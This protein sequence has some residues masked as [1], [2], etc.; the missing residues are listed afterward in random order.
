MEEKERI[1]ETELHALADAACTR[2]FTSRPMFKSLVEDI[3]PENITAYLD[4]SRLE[5]WPHGNFADI[6][7]ERGG[8]VVWRAGLKDGSWCYP[9]LVLELGSRP[10]HR[11]ALRM[12]AYAA[13]LLQSI[14]ER[15]GLDENGRLSWVLPIVLYSGA[16]DWKEPLELAEYF[17]DMPEDLARYIPH[18]SYILVDAGRV[19][20]DV[21][22]VA[23]DESS[24]L[25]AQFFR[26]EQVT[27]I[28]QFEKILGRL[29]ELTHVGDDHEDAAELKRFD[30][31]FTRWFSL[32]F[33]HFSN[34]VDISA[35]LSDQGRTMLEQNAASW[36]SS[37]I[38]RGY[39]TGFKAGLQILL[40]SRFGPLSQSVT[41]AIERLNDAV[42]A[43][44]LRRAAR[45]ADS[46]EAFMRQMPKA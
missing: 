46:L 5:L 19:K 45:Q 40:E 43:K 3:V 17:R 36:K 24:G 44:E 13:L 20:S 26:M 6:P 21:R 35:P 30:R 38:Q 42:L 12:F 25:A 28:R 31:L 4:L 7:Q 11:M 10:E 9:F 1:S 15:E 39:L 37:Q 18:M 14:F 22:G 16:D 34:D 2:L 29:T 27:D 32:A 33:L 23:L 8:I 41:D